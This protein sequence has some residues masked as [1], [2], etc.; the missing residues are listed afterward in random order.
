MIC[1]GQLLTLCAA[2]GLVV[3]SYCLQ[4]MQSAFQSI[5]DSESVCCMA[6]CPA[7]PLPPKFLGCTTD[8]SSFLYPIYFGDTPPTLYE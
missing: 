4:C 1:H 6:P 3:C 8:E 5:A 7:V 2:I